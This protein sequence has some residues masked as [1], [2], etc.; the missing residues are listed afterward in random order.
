MQYMTPQTSEQNNRIANLRAVATGYGVLMGVVAAVEMVRVSL[1]IGH[2]A[3]QLVD[4]ALS[5]L[6]LGGALAAGHWARTGRPQAGAWLLA[7]T[8]AL[9]GGLAAAL[10]APASYELLW[11]LYVVPVIIAQIVLTSRIGLLVGLGSLPMFVFTYASLAERPELTEQLPRAV[12]TN[13]WLYL[14]VGGLVH[15]ALE[16]MGAALRQ[17]DRAL[18]ASERTRAELHEREEQF[19]A[20]AESSATGIIIQQ[21]GHLVYGNPHFLAMAGV[22]TGNSFGLSL[23]DFF[24]ESGVEALKE[25]LARRQ[26]G[27]ARQVP[28]SEVTF[29]PLQGPARWFEVAVAEAVFWGKEAVVGNLLDVTDRVEAQLAVQRERDFVNS[30]IDTAGALIMALDVRGQV[31][32][33]NPAAESLTG[34]ETAE[35]A[36]RPYWEVMAPPDGQRQVRDMYEAIIAGDPQGQAEA[37]WVTKNGDEIIIAWHISALR[38]PDGQ[39]SG[40]VAIGIDVTQQRILERQAM[41]TER[42]RALGQVSGGVAHDLNNML[43][44]IMGPADL[45]LMDETDPERERALNAILAAA[46]RGAETVRRIQRFS[47]A[48]TDLDKQEFDLREMADDVIFTLRP[49]WRD[50][51]QKQGITLQVLNEVPAGIT[52]HASAGEIGNVLMN[53]IVNACEAM[54]AGGQIT[55]TGQ[56]LD[57]LVEFQVRDNGVGMS[58]ET[59][60]QIFQ[61]F[62]STKGADNSG[63]GLAVIHGIILRHG[64]NINVDSLPGEGT[65]FTITLPVGG[66]ETVSQAQAANKE[67]NMDTL[68]VLVVDDMPDLANYIAAVCNRSGHQAEAAYTGEAAV[69]RLEVQRF[70]LLITDYGME[71]IAGPALAEKGRALHP[72][73]KVV[74]VTGWD[75]S[76]EEAATFDGVLIKP[77]SREQIQEIL[78]TFVSEKGGE[79]PEQT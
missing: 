11:P 1:G 54:P 72:G 47:K 75:L 29:T 32:R 26:R 46:K 57:D 39:L 40:M 66:D 8:A 25:Q 10:T 20:L 37:T 21:D 2:V 48:R 52:V 64:G 58:S 38:D 9:R 31:V 78:Q 62:Y 56:Q 49:R 4:A 67:G 36:D 33:F 71:G 3:A 69:K 13:L 14:L 60:E 41:A 34:Y 55:V 27:I 35:L 7:I 77:C 68:Q 17:A 70:D 63:L 51:A 16:R 6:A 65:T 45:M 74:L 43:A 59:V 44:G 5:V 73:I 22:R 28:P 79:Q 53:L 42:L 30:L 24:T 12:A 18:G 50:G 61:P 23:W 15:I 19:R 76:D